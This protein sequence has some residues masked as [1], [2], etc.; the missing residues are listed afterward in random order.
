MITIGN[1]GA[2]T[3]IQ[4]QGRRG[5]RHLGISWSGAFD[6]PAAARANSLVGNDP[7]AAVLEILM[8]GLS[9]NTDA[10][11]TFALTGAPA[12]ATVTTSTMARNIH[13]DQ[14]IQLTAGDHVEL[15]IPTSGIRTYISFAGGI[16]VEPVLG[17]RSRDTLGA[18]GPEPMAAGQ[19]LKIRPSSQPAPTKPQTPNYTASTTTDLASADIADALAAA[20][21]ASPSHLTQPIPTLLA[22]PTTHAA[23]IQGDLAELLATR[24]W[25]VG[26]RSSRIGIRLAGDPLLADYP[27]EWGSEPTVPG[28]IQLAPNGELI[29]FGPDGP[30]TGGYPVIAVAAKE[31]IT[32]L[33]QMRSGS[34]LKIKIWA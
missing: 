17:S 1:P 34:Q 30:T 13:P 5:L 3:L 33:S 20:K 7:S 11:V 2:L 19:I 29:I 28:S 12:P 22:G 32:A 8:G 26:D 15:G 31:A 9:F 4:D 10:T 23:L 25:T 6:S 24:T 27:T 14:P 16:D 18:L 21:A